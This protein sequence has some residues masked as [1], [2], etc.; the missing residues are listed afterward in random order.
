MLGDIGHL[1]Y[2]MVSYTKRYVPG[3]DL[4]VHHHVANVFGAQ[5]IQMVKAMIPDV[6]TEKIYVVLRSLL[7]VMETALLDAV[8]W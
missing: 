6:N 5:R 4:D 3:A 8:L 7:F 2:N 1:P